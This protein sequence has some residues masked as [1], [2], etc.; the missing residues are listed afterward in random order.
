[1]K[2]YDKEVKLYCLYR[3]FK[4]SLVMPIHFAVDSKTNEYVV[5]YVHLKDG[6]IY[7]R[8]L[9]EWFDV[10]DEKGYILYREDNSTKQLYR[11]EEVKDNE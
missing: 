5:V 6:T 7:T 3:H 11:F 8:P 4:G 2:S 9:K 10:V 1:M